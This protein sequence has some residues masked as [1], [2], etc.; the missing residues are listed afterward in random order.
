MKPTTPY[1]N[2]LEYLTEPVVTANETA[3][4]VILNHMDVNPGPK[5]PVV[6]DFPDVFPKEL[7]IKPPK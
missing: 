5:V 6:N 3:N 7:P 2:E 1:G 4:N